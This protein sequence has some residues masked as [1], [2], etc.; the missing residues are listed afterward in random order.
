MPT[1]L[2]SN[3]LL[4]ISID[5]NHPHFLLTILI[6]FF[7]ALDGQDSILLKILVWAKEQYTPLMLSGIVSNEDNGPT[8]T[9]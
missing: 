9:K 8:K 5:T 1:D 7:S 4:P 2:A 6:F 3:P